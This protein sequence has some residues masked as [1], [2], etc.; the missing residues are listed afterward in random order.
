[1]KNVIYSILIIVKNDKGIVATL[2]KLREIINKDTTEIIVVDGSAESLNDIREEYKEVR[3]I[4]FESKANKKITIPEQRNIAIQHATGSIIIFLDASCV[5]AKNW[6]TE[7][8][9][10]ISSGEE[11]IVAGS[12]LSTDIN[13][14]H[15][16]RNELLKDLKYL[17]EAPTINL[18]MNK[19]VIDKVGSFDESFDYGS[20]VDFTMRAIKARYKI[21]YNAKAIITHDWG[22]LTDDFKR[23]FRYGKA[24]VNIYNK[25][26]DKL[27][28]LFSNDYITLIYPVFLLLLPLTIIWPF[29]PLLLLIPMLKNY[30]SHP[31][32]T[33]AYNTVYGAGILVR[34]KEKFI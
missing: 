24:R 5:P 25:H 34:L 33:T 32:Y 21:R 20:D 7:L 4:S 10:L 15:N 22:S 26:R 28:N 13:G 23:A 2:S 11:K 27:I 18:A 1:M 19:S 30:K 6:F 29:Y 14:H 3:W 17:Q 16:L 31:V 12:V 9:S 8:T